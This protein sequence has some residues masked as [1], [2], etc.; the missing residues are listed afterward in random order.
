MS[1]LNL[2]NA[3]LKITINSKGAELLSL[4]NKETQLEYLWNGDA[5]YWPKTSPV[6]FPIVGGLKNNEYSFE[7]KKY[8]L[9][10]HGF[11]RDNEYEVKQVDETKIVFTLKSN[12][13]TLANYPFH[14]IFSVEYSIEKNKLYC[15]YF[16]QNTGE[17]KMYFSVGAHPAFN[18][19]LSNNT[20]FNDWFLEFNT[21]ENCGIYPI[22]AAGLIENKAVPFLNNTNQ[23]ALTKELFYKDA[24]IFK[25]LQ[26]TQIKI[27]SNL[28]NNGLA[29]DFK[30]FPYYGIWAA[31]DA[32]FVCLEPW[33]GLG[34]AE[35]TTSDITTKEGIEILNSQ[36]TFERVWSIEMY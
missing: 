32:N 17:N 13:T 25:E 33:C 7:D 4:Y 24:L 22:N 34:D 1:V 10:R 26:S 21:N 20:S 28:S 9:T 11:A 6:L 23:L 31:K 8:T 2:E 29:M 36:Q 35:N 30:G 27:K 3:H 16:V 18:I 15:K 14:F 12:E 5:N 19:P